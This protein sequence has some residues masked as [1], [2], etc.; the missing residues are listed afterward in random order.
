MRNH[1][2]SKQTKIKL[3]SS[4]D[5]VERDDVTAL[6]IFISRL[7]C[8]TLLNECIHR[9]KVINYG[10]HDLKFL[11]TITDSNKFGCKEF[12]AVE[13]SIYK[14][15]IRIQSSRDFYFS[16]RHGKTYESKLHLHG[17]ETPYQAK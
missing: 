3:K 9:Y 16:C 1:P 8:E 6:N 14:A 2:I 4:L 7:N 17:I 15:R 11:Y 13:I 12:K 5:L 10:H